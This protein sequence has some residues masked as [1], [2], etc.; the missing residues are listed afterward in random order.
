LQ[1]PSSSAIFSRA[2][3]NVSLSSTEK[4]LGILG[5]P[6]HNNVKKSDAQKGTDVAGTVTNTPRKMGQEG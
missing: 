5:L 1:Q 3:G 2:K 6:K 4:N